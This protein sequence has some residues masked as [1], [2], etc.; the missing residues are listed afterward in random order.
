MPSKCRASSAITHSVLI[1]CTFAA[2]VQAFSGGA[3]VGGTHS[4]L[5][6]RPSIRCG[7]V[8]RLRMLDVGL[9]PK[10]GFDPLKLIEEENEE[11]MLRNGDW[12]CKAASVAVGGILL[13]IPIAAKAVGSVSADIFDPGISIHYRRTHDPDV[14][15]LAPFY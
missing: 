14:H 1:L 9:G 3:V 13:A 2:V 15:L 4:N 6:L 12:V 11:A 10:R 5:G 8:H 7:R